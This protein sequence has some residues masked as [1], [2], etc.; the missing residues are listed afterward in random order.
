MKKKKKKKEK[1]KETISLIAI[2]VYL[3]S[4]K[5]GIIRFIWGCEFDTISANCC[6]AIS[7]GAF[8]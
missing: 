4:R 7:E 6:F 5:L 3:W 2:N 1:K 8:K